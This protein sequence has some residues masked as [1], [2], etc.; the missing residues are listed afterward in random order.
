LVYTKEKNV[1]VTMEFEIPKRHIS[2]SILSTDML[3]NGFCGGRGYIPKRCYN[4]KKGK[5]PWLRNVVQYIFDEY[6]L[7][8]KR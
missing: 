8:K 4:I 1:N 5:G 7:G 2:R 6:F 3:Q